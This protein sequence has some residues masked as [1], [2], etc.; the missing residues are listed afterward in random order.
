MPHINKKVH[1]FN[2][3][4][5]L[6]SVSVKKILLHKNL[7]AKRMVFSVYVFEIIYGGMLGKKVC[8]CDFSFATGRDEVQVNPKLLPQRLVMLEPVL[9]KWNKQHEPNSFPSSFKLSELI[10]Y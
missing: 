8:H 4:L 3:G 7:V 1:H 2:N 10:S 6:Y 5:K 9:M